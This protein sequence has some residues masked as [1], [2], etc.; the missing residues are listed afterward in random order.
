MAAKAATA[1][2]YCRRLFYLI[3]QQIFTF[4]EADRPQMRAFKTYRG[5]ESGS[6][7]PASLAHQG[8]DDTRQL[9]QGDLVPC[10][11]L[12]M[13]RSREGDFLG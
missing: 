11:K 9:R 13:R 4:S 6:G 3:R 1:T 12:S 5:D 10:I 2:P 8:A 7:K